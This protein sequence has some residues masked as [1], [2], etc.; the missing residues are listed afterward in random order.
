MKVFEGYSKLI[1]KARGIFHKKYHK[2]FLHA[3]DDNEESVCTNPVNYV[4]FKDS[5]TEYIFLFTEDGNF[6]R[7]LEAKTQAKICDCCAGTGINEC[8]ECEGTGF[9]VLP[10]G[11]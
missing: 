11:E 2:S 3:T 5:R 8:P 6:I 1:N 4:I 9:K 10:L 7:M